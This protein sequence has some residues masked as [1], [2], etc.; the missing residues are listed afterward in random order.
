MATLRSD[1][2]DI[3]IVAV[4]TVTTVTPAGVSAVVDGRPHRFN[5]LRALF[6]VA[7]HLLDAKGMTP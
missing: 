5:D 7:V 1:P 3:L 4:I 6:K 2:D